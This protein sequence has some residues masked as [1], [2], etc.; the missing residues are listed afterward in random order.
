M[1]KYLQLLYKIL[2]GRVWVAKWFKAKNLCKIMKSL[3][4]PLLKESFSFTGELSRG[5]IKA[6]LFLGLLSVDLGVFPY[7][8]GVIIS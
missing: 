3:E 7:I 8:F 2:L 5:D 6:F 1:K 4:S